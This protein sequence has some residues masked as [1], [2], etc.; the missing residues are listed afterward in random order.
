MQFI[1]QTNKKENFTNSFKKDYNGHMKTSNK[2]TLVRIIMAPVFL[3]LYMLPNWI[4]MSQKSAVILT[5]IALPLLA[6]AEFTD[7]LDGHFARKHNEVSDFGKMFDPFADV[8]LHMTTFL[9]FTITGYMPLIFFMLIFYREFAMNFFRMVAAKKGVAIAAR[10]G[11]KTKTVLYVFTGFYC[12][13][14]EILSRAWLWDSISINQNI[15]KYIAIG[16]YA[17]CV[18]LSYASFIDYLVNFGY[19]LKDGANDKQ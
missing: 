14:L 1:Q 12:L 11:G 7:Y 10:K 3:V 16:L 17:L 19:V 6:F 18:I 15:F 5:I 2:F 4:S 9:C 8:F 13:V